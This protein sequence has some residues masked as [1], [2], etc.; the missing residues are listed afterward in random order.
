[1][2][3]D[4]DNDGLGS[5][6]GAN[7]LFNQSSPCGPE[8]PQALGAVACAAGVACNEVDNNLAQDTNGQPTAGAAILLQTD[9]DFHADRFE[10]RGNQGAHA[11]RGV[12][13]AETIL[14][15]CLLADNQATQDLIDISNGFVSDFTMESCT[16]ANNQIGGSRVILA[17]SNSVTLLDSIIDQPGVLTLD[18]GDANPL[19]VDYILSTD[20]STLPGLPGVIQGEPTF[21]DAANGDYHLQAT[22]LGVDFAPTAAGTDLDRN[23]RTVD[24]PGVPNVHGSLD[25]GAYEIQSGTVVVGCAIADTIFCDG[26]EGQ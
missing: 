5:Y 26:F 19:T 25:L 22:S 23:P 11:L 7:V 18:A 20:L 17:Q 13:T 24:L 4:E 14:H 15:D 3:G 9:S 10:M 12:E 2:Y 6:S 21:V 16:L 8:S 1:V